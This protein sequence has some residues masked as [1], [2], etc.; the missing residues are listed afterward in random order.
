LR[1][2][3]DELE[4]AGTDEC[5]GDEEDQ[6]GRQDSATVT[7]STIPKVRVRTSRSSLPPSR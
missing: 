7:R 2:D 4:R 5:T 6:R 1:G 3:V